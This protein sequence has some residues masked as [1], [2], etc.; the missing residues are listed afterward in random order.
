MGS[1]IYKPNKKLE[2]IVNGI[3]DF[4]GDCMPQSLVNNQS[5]KQCTID[6]K[7]RNQRGNNESVIIVDN[8]R[9]KKI[10]NT[11]IWPYCAI[12]LVSMKFNKGSGW[13]TGTLI[14]SNV[15]LTCAHNIYDYVQGEA[16]SISVE[17][18]P[19]Y[20]KD[21]IICYSEVEK[22]YYPDEYEKQSYNDYSY[23]EDYAIL[24][25]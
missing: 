22:F 13:G 8:D 9:R 14:S 12:G 5:Y 4:P 19:G 3:Y 20:N 17:F 7:P 25:F 10:E 15:V 6:A 2:E 24:I 1:L 18:Y 21:R 23:P 11:K 16:I